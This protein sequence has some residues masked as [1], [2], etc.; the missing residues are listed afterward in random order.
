MKYQI[1]GA[2]LLIP[3][4]SVF[5]ANFILL[6][7][8]YEE[9]RLIQIICNCVL[10][11]IEVAFNLKLRLIRINP[12]ASIRRGPESCNSRSIYMYLA[13]GSFTGSCLFF[14]TPPFRPLA[15]PLARLWP[16]SACSLSDPSCQILSLYFPL[17]C[18]GTCMITN[19]GGWG[20]WSIVRTNGGAVK[21]PP[22]FLII[23][24]STMILNVKIMTFIIGI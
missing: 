18:S 24:S 20:K 3:A 4:N 1:P 5:L 13:F 8:Y 17:T 12:N 15:P 16:D 21:L 6:I 22:Q 11:K 9:L 10:K 19:K 14:F 7:S 23:C 2:V